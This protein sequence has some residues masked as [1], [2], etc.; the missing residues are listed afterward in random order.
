MV[1]A[2]V[3]AIGDG[4]V[5]EE[6]GEHLMHRAQHRRAP[7]TL[8]KVS[9]WPANEASG[10]SSAVAEERTATAISLAAAHLRERRRAPPA[11]APCGNGVAMIATV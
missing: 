7:R 8:R 4:A 10:R 1:E 2:L 3:H 6:R 9:C 5:V 11:R